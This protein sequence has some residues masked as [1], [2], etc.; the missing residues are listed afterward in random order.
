MPCGTQR[1][2]AESDPKPTVKAIK[3]LCCLSADTLR[4]ACCVPRGVL[5][6]R[7]AIIPGT[8][9]WCKGHTV[10]SL[11]GVGRLI[12]CPLAFLVEAEPGSCVVGAD[13]TLGRG[14]GLEKEPSFSWKSEGRNSGCGRE[15]AP[16]VLM[17]GKVT[18]RHSQMQLE[19][20]AAEGEM[21]DAEAEGGRSEL[22]GVER[23]RGRGEGGAALAH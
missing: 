9:R 12:L 18:A 22:T 11:Y 6:T 7:H 13:W 19:G 16:G 23:Q 4:V 21:G 17:K 20:N 14:G 2:T 10:A 8:R 1:G 15:S 3:W 5:V